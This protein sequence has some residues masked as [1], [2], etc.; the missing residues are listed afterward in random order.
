[1]SRLAASF[2]RLAATHRKALVPYVT[3][4]HPGREITVPLMNAMVAAGAD[5]IE[6]GVPFS[7]PMADGPVIQRANEAALARG[8]GLRDVLAMVREFRHRD[9]VTPVVLM[10]YANPVERMGIALFL[11]EALSAGVDGLIVVDYPP[12]ESEDFAAAARARG[13][14]LV[15][16]LA[17]TSTDERIEHVARLASGYVYYVSLKGI[18][19]AGHLDTAEVAQRVARIKRSTPL[20]VGVGFGIR[21]AV[22]AKAIAAN[23][24]AVIIGTRMIQI[25]EDG[26]AAGAPA[27]AA[28]FL[29]EVRAALDELQ[30]AAAKTA[31]A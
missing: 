28:A 25:L 19:G 6:L 3:A 17:P 8:V 7:D 18:T 31:S 29:A 21:D 13:I 30:P 12:E 2:A 24:D 10:G 4:G 16:L 26:D 11:D 14:D 5:V 1:M 23:A 9:D 20:P 27:R 22:T 15:F